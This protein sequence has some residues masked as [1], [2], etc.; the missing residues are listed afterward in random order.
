MASTFAYRN[1][2]LH[3]EDVPLPEIARQFGTPCYVYSRA[4]LTQAYREFDAA[5]ASHAHLICYAVKANSNL[6]ILN[7][8]AKLG[9]GFDIVSGGELARVHIARLLAGE[10]RLLLADE[11]IANLDPRYQLDILAAL[12][13]HARSRG[14]ALVVLHDLNIAARHCDRLLLLAADHPPLCD[15]PARVLSAERVAEVFKVPLGYFR[16]AGIAAALAR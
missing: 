14:A 3:A 5:F 10:H 15:T 1:G 13:G 4:A 16:E 9:S 2:I 11:P 6:A 12:S 7:L 8:F